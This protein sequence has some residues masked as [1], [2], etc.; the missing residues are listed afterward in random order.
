[1]I[2]AA[3]IRWSP[4]ILWSPAIRWSP[5][6]HDQLEVWT[7]IIQKST[8]IPP[9]LMVLLQNER[10]LHKHTW[11]NGEMFLFL[12]HGFLQNWFSSVFVSTFRTGGLVDF[13]VKMFSTISCSLPPDFACSRKV[14]SIPLAHQGQTSRAG[15]TPSAASF[16]VI[17]AAVSISWSSFML[18]QTWSFLDACTDQATV[19]LL[20]DIVSSYE[21]DAH[22][23]LLDIVRIT[24]ITDHG[25]T[26]AEI[27][28]AT[29][30]CLQLPKLVLSQPK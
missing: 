24:S 18:F 28:D 6:I 12:R 29:K 3:A 27:S 30:P 22:Q 1:M 17:T 10:L 5:A 23:L 26:A 7:L 20:A 15:Q 25:A 2:P 19:Q 21:Y 13:T 16:C 11:W 8:V 4:G 9:S 14:E